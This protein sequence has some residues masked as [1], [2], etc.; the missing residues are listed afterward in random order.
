MTI[1]RDFP[2]LAV[3]ISSSGVVSLAG[4]G[5]GQ[6][7][8]AGARAAI[9]TGAAALKTAAYTAVAGDV[10]ACNTITTGAFTITLPASPA[11]GAA[12]IIIF[13]A[14]TSTTLNGFATNNLTIA[15]NGNTIHGLAEDVI[16]STKGVTI[17]IEYI[18][19]T[20]ILRNG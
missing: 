8:L 17:V 12:P 6:S 2:R 16:V 20:W 3:N 18:G 11:A 14:G 19:G 9:G 13:D 10:L 4:G 15:R 1:A 7:T 5:T